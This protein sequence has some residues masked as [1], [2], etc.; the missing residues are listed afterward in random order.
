MTESIISEKFISNARALKNPSL[1]LYM[2]KFNFHRQLTELF[3]DQEN[4]LAYNQEQ[5]LSFI[6][7]PFSVK[8]FEKQI[9][10]KEASFTAEN[11]EL[12]FTELCNKYT[13]YPHSSKVK[14]N[15]QL[16]QNENTFTIT[17]GHQLSIVN[18]FS[19]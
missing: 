4:Q 10:Q 7:L 15:I 13:Q 8:N 19:F 11:R 16:I 2:Q 14:N 18:V 5:L 3:T 17:T 1:N 6:N 9:S 12:L